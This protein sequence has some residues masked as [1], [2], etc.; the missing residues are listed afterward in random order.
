M[1]CN[2]FSIEYQAR[3]CELG[4]RRMNSDSIV[5]PFSPVGL[6]IGISNK[7]LHTNIIKKCPLTFV[8]TDS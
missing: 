6:G 8:D 3:W 4:Y 7:S 5:L 2:H 1:Q